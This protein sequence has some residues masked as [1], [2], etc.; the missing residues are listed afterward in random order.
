MSTLILTTL[1]LA[2]SVP[3]LA[4][5]QQAGSLPSSSDAQSTGGVILVTNRDDDTVTL[6]D[7]LTLEI[8]ATLDVG[9]SPHEV[10]A[11]PAG[12]LA[13]VSS[14]DRA[15]A[16]EDSISVSVVDVRD[17]SIQKNLH[18]PG[19]R[20]LHGIALSPDGSRLWLSAENDQSVLEVDAST[21]QLI[22]EFPTGGEWTHVVE[23]SKDGRTLY[24]ADMARGEVAF[25]NRADASVQ[26][27]HSGPGAEGMALSP[28]GATL[29]VAK[30]EADSLAILDAG[31]GRRVAA[32]STEG[33]FPVK[34]RFSP[35]GA[36]VWVTNNRGNS[37]A[38][39]DTA[40]RQVTRVVPLPTQPLGVNFSEDGKRV[41]VSAPRTDQLLVLDRA[42][43]AL[44]RRISVGGS[45]DGVAW[46]RIR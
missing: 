43:G 34:I 27:N 26:V 38:V 7:G 37:L 23:R 13:Y 12:G 8:V 35:D 30:R 36:E 18:I 44:E 28:D 4:T 5:A 16:D 21:G 29:W 17:R 22:R 33:D 3:G 10:V 32:V 46:V 45:P 1:I 15:D 14:Y 2:M 19:R 24:A 11:A 25:I 39:I 20:G 40:T 31:T 9:Q 41:F 6:I 42:S